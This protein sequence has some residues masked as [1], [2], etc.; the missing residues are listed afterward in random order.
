[1]ETCCTLYVM[2]F[3]YIALI[4]SLTNECQSVSNGTVTDTELSSKSIWDSIG[5]KFERINIILLI[6]NAIIQV[7]MLIK[8][9]VKSY[10]I[11]DNKLIQYFKTFFLLNQKFINQTEYSPSIRER[12]INNFTFYIALILFV[13]IFAYVLFLEKFPIKSSLK[14]KK[15]NIF[16]K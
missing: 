2:C 6:V 11:S 5:H 7:H 4:I 9:I 1:M 15:R 14:V 12:F 10:E 3:I 8:T 13:N 16:R